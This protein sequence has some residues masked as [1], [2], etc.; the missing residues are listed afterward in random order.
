MIHRLTVAY[1]IRALVL[2][3]AAVAAAALVGTRGEP[4]HAAFQAGRS[5]TMKLRSKLIGIVV[6]AASAVA[7]GATSAPAQGTALPSDP[8]FTFPKQPR[9]DLTVSSIATTWTRFTVANVGNAPAGP[10]TVAVGPRYGACSH[11][12]L[13]LPPPIWTTIRVNRLAVGAFVQLDVEPSQWARYIAVDI[14]REVL[15][16]GESSDGS[17]TLGN[18]FAGLPGEFYPCPT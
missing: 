1:R 14:N 8:L 9:P 7:L 16:L 4:V 11:D 12:F 2:A 17:R 13:L 18:N 15:E 10:F 6:L 3:T 5:K